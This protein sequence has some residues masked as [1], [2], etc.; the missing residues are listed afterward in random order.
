M[1][2]IKDEGGE[3]ES[4]RPAPAHTPPFRGPAG[5]AS[6]RQPLRAAAPVSGRATVPPFMPPIQQGGP[7]PGTSRQPGLVAPYATPFAKPRRPAATPVM[8]VPVDD[9]SVTAE[10]TTRV[11]PYEGEQYF[12]PVNSPLSSP[13]GFEGFSDD[14]ASVTVELRRVPQIY[15]SP[16]PPVVEAVEAPAAPPADESILSIDAYV[17][18]PEAAAAGMAVDESGAADMLGD[19]EADPPPAYFSIDSPMPIAAAV[20][21]PPIPVPDA[22]AADAAALSADEVERE[23]QALVDAIV[24]AVA[25][26]AD[27]Q[28]AARDRKIDRDATRLFT[29]DP[30]GEPGA[31]AV[32]DPPDHAGIPAGPS[33]FDDEPDVTH[34]M[35]S[36]HIN[37]FA[38]SRYIVERPVPP[39]PWSPP[40]LTP[41]GPTPASIPSVTP[42]FGSP[43][44]PRPPSEFPPIPPFGKLQRP[45]PT[46][47]TP[48][49]PPRIV[50][51][52]SMAAVAGVPPPT[53]SRPTPV[54]SPTPVF[55]PTPTPLSVPA[56]PDV[57]GARAVAVA[58]ETVAAR[59]RA[60]HL[61]VR[62]E[63]SESLDEDATHAGYLAAALA[64][65]LGVRHKVWRVAPLHLRVTGRV[66][67]VG[68]R[69]YIRAEAER[70]GLAG[71]VRNRPDGSVELAADGPRHA[72][73][74]LLAA[75]QR[76]P[77]SA[78]VDRVESLASSPGDPPASTP[79]RV[80][81]G[82]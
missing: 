34:N 55:V 54:R 39:E 33:P 69:W 63:V 7:R 24:G 19:G 18:R 64:A 4:Q 59:I 28:D 77:P 8:Q 3:G 14:P 56:I 70:L 36:G 61:V 60:G 5:P 49:L 47:V 12:A 1:P 53:A 74:A 10:H 31:D 71:W 42:A 80:L 9:A 68:F 40:G 51:P 20:P 23:R 25:H 73:D 2:D 13:A 26:A 30:F 43:A 45:T 21:L 38:D 67:G 48:I 79:F 44:A 41:W 66:Q 29:D 58:L 76:G 11:V 15:A 6:S 75:V 37:D 17:V 78:V 50:T 62:G 35:M 65:L 27:D 72:R 16:E 32:N 82:S 81:H 46:H 22:S 52:L 57:A